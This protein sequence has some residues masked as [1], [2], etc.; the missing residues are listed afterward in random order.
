MIAK[1]RATCA[2][3]DNSPFDISRCH[4]NNSNTAIGFRAYKGAPYSV[5]PENKKARSPRPNR[6]IGEWKRNKQAPYMSGKLIGYMLN[7]PMA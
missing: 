3:F 7:R 4:P 5:R 1:R 6:Q 2:V